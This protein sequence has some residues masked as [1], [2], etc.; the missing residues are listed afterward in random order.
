MADV[1][2]DGFTGN[3]QAVAVL[4]TGAFSAH[5]FLSGKVIAEACFS[6]GGV[7][8]GNTLCP[9]GQGSQTGAGATN[10]T[11]A[12]CDDAIA[13][14]C[15]HGTHVAG[16]A[17]GRNTAQVAGFPTNG[18]AKGAKIFAIQVFTRNGDTVGAFV[19][20]QI[21]AL[22]HVL[23]NLT[24][25][26]GVKVAAINMSLGNITGNTTPC[27]M[28]SRKTVIDNL[29]AAGVLT[30]ISSGNFSYTNAGGSPG[31]IS[32]ALT[33]GA[34]DKSDVIAAYS[35]MSTMVD[36]MAPGGS[37]DQVTCMPGVH[38]SNVIVGPGVDLANGTH[39]YFCLAGTSMA[40]P[41]VA[42]A[43]AVLKS[44]CPLAT[45]DQIENALK[46]TGTPIVDGRAG[47]TFTKPRIRVS[48]ALDAL[49]CLP[50]ATATTT[51]VASSDATSVFGQSV[52]LVAKVSA[53]AGTPAG[54]VVFKD[55]AVVLGTK[56][57]VAG[58]AVLP[59]PS[60]AVRAH[61]IRATYNGNASFKTST[62]AI[63]K[64]NRRQGR[65]DHRENHRFT[66]GAGC[67]KSRDV[68]S[69]GDGQGA[70]QW[71]TNRERHV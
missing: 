14:I 35:N 70:R 37:D 18:V 36:V 16:I 68:D 3:G 21:L 63:L 1:Y 43:V 56:P 39:T 66:G 29:R 2:A 47:G 20:D 50:I 10:P 51:T 8:G 6:N 67:R 44:A 49:D 26:G 25:P 4:D 23:A 27:D 12:N 64:A 28:D 58:R 31:C 15:Y 34:T 54:S 60:L 7:A 41:H 46:T 24:L 62:S 32:T 5:E 30:V 65:D 48:Q 17:A 59:V 69:R 19:S 52:N 38:G 45:A 57:I 42:G 13:S 9:N 40:A 61:N 55:G 53:A 22:E 33:V 11:I 71:H